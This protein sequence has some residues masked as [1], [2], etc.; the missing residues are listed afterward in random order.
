MKCQNCAKVASLHITEILSD[1]NFEEVHLCEECAQK[2]LYDPQPKKKS[3]SSDDVV[4]A[5]KQCGECGMKFVD[6][7]NG[8]RLGCPHDY[9]AFREELLPLLESIHNSSQHRGKRPS[10]NPVPTAA[11]SDVGASSK[12]PRPDPKTELPKLRK[13]LEECIAQ[14]AYERAAKIRD[15]IRQMEA[16]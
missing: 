8:G 12:S 16:E 15:R 9:T 5:E 7:R 14:E 1:Q 11:G 2:Y 6:F 10:R 3:A 4:V 13:Q